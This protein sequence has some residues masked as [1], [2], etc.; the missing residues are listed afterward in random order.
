M[1]TEEKS[2]EL[3]EA[4]HEWTERDERDLQALILLYSEGRM[5]QD[6]LKGLQARHPETFRR[7]SSFAE[8]AKGGSDR[9]TF[10]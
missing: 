3:A 5:T 7:L 8:N 9:T 6:Q 1:A 10:N 2:E 4:V